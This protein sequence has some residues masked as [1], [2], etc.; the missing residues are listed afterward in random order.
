[1]A[2][3]NT[4]E[5][6]LS[7][8]DRASGTIRETFGT[9][10]SSSNRAI[11]VVKAGAALAASAMAAAG[12]YVAK[13]GV[14]Y[15]AMAEQSKV[16][17]TTL[18]GSQEKAKT[19][20]Q[21]IAN[22]AKSTPFETEQVDTMAKY[23]N[24]AGLSGKALFDQLMRVS[25]VASAF[26]IPADSAEELARQ[27]SQV[28][29]SGT[30]YT[31]DLNILGDRGVPILQALSKE[32]GVSVGE[33]KN[34]AS[35]GKITSDVYMKAF[36]DIANSVKGASDA[37]SQTFSGLLSTLSDNLKMLSGALAQPLF[38]GLKDGLNMVM[39]LLGG[40]TSLAK[41]DFKGF[42]D[43]INQTFGSGMGSKIISFAQNLGNGFGQISGFVD[44]AKQA[45]SGIF[46]IAA[47]NEGKGVSI[48]NM[49]GFSSDAISQIQGFINGIK[50]TVSGFI[51]GVKALFSGDN[52]FMSSFIKIFNTAKSIIMPIINDIVSFFREKFSMIK[53]FWDENGA[54]IIQAIKNFVAVIAAIFQ[55]IAPVVLAILKILWDSVKG[56]IDGALKVI[57]GLIKVFA[58]LFTGNFGKMWEG[59]KQIFFGAIELV[60][61]WIN[62]LFVGRI[63]GGIKTFIT[64]GITHFTGFWTKAWEI[65]KNLD[66]S[67]SGTVSGFVGK[68]VGF[69]RD[70]WT[71]AVNIFN[72]LRAF[73]ASIFESLWQSIANTAGRIASSVKGFFGDMVTGAKWQIQ[74]LLDSAAGIFNGIKNAITNPIGTAKDIILGFIDRIKGAFSNMGVKIS[75]P[76]FSVSNFSL[77]PKDWI[78]HG[79]P[80]LSVDWYDKGG[81]FYGPQVIGVG[82][83]RPEFVGAL[84]DLRK[85]VREETGGGKGGNNYYVTVNK[86]D[87][88]AEVV[89]TLKRLEV[90]YG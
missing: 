14:D 36:G 21:D 40:L 86:E 10:E 49:L 39:P 82:E 13:L 48:L 85:I 65:F 25:D 58:G 68:V 76:H 61:N 26:N 1:M 4:V 19:M 44:K 62:L 69:I 66:T 18:L 42:S 28:M 74:S 34:M 16:A 70:L 9:L 71:N 64:E 67:I 78:D 77:N 29:Q 12:G 43:T 2:G 17:W 30:A 75:L 79:L 90:L 38:N 45:L 73:G 35:N 31:E 22:F 63:L 89:R 83:K 46:N 15:D 51:N 50:S 20:L 80:K 7:A 72:Q 81:I 8:A 27:M 32:M 56:I 3:G 54:Q 60:W 6:I 37:Q 53:Q 41:G 88:A 55:F 33:V 52:D 84:D 59:I 24:N 57:M 23:M 87:T 5:I 47:G 11:S